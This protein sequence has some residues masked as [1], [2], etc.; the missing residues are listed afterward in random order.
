MVPLPFAATPTPTLSSLAI[1]FMLEQ[2]V[3]LDERVGRVFALVLEGCTTL[4]ANFVTR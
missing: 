2:L 1:R 3:E 4:G